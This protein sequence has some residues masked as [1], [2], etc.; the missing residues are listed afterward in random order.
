MVPDPLVQVIQMLFFEHGVSRSCCS[1]GSLG[2]GEVILSAKFAFKAL[3]DARIKLTD[4]NGTLLLYVKRNFPPSIV[5]NSFQQKAVSVAAS[6][7][8][9][10]KLNVEDQSIVYREIHCLEI[11]EEREEQGY[12]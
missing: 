4:T 10:S 6:T 5:L 1:L 2:Q 7:Q 12:M 8:K 11:L 9:Y 3:R